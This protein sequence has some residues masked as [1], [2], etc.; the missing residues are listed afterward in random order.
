[1]YASLNDDI[2]ILIINKLSY[3]NII[4]LLQLNKKYNKLCKENAEN[5]TQVIYNNEVCFMN[6]KSIKIL[7][8]CNFNNSIRHLSYYDLNLFKKYENLT[9]ENVIISQVYIINNHYN[10]N[11][12]Y[13]KLY[14][15]NLISYFNPI[16]YLS[17]TSLIL[18]NNNSSI[19][20]NT[21]YDNNI[22]MNN[23]L[24]LTKLNTLYIENSLSNTPC[25]LYK[26]TSLT[27]ITSLGLCNIRQDICNNYIFLE[28]MTRLKKLYLNKN[29]S[30]LK[31]SAPLF[32]E[33]FYVQSIY[34]KIT[35][36]NYSHAFLNI[37]I[38]DI[39]NTFYLYSHTIYSIIKKYYR[40]LEKFYINNC[41]IGDLVIN[42]ISLFITENIPQL[43]LDFYLKY[44][45][46]NFNS[47]IKLHNSSNNI[48]IYVSKHDMCLNNIKNPKY[49]RIFIL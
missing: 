26:L 30:D 45:R 49:D 44:N 10:K 14:N 22:I 36:F 15:T 2:I 28:N 43:K 4:N 16:N 31:Y 18:I 20:I 23:L 9:F 40:T 19:F 46:F 8:D 29:N 35:Q 13:L 42:N 17:L 1:M 27:N 24:L 11:I 47:L 38:I 34:S 39:S 25:D 12:K 21:N 5:I 7:A 33:E 37:K 48:N 41:N 32:L 6:A 3:K